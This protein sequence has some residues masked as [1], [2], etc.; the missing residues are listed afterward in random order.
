MIRVEK[1]ETTE[2]ETLEEGEFKKWFRSVLMKTAGDANKSQQP[3]R[4]SYLSNIIICTDFTPGA[5]YRVLN[6]WEAERA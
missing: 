1:G 2:L 4:P 6:S 5:R 3:G